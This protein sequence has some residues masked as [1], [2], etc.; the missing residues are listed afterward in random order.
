MSVT[1]AL[2]CPVPPVPV[3]LS[4]KVVALVRAAVL[5]LPAVAFDPDQPPE[6]VHAVAFVEVQVSVLLPPLATEVGD[7]DSETV[8]AGVAAVTVTDAVRCVV[9]PAPLQLS[10]YE[11]L[12]L[13]A[14]VLC[15][16]EVDFVP[17]QLPDAV[18]DVAFDVDHDKVLL[19]PLVTD[20]GDAEN[21]TVGAGVAAVTVTDALRWVVPPAPLQL[22]VYEA[23]EVSAPVPCEPDVAFDPLQLPD[24]VHD[25]AFEVD[26]DKVLL[27]PLVTEVG[28]AEKETVGAG[29]AA[30]TVTDAVRCVVPPEPEQ[31]SVYEA[32]AVSAPVLC[33][34]DVD[35]DPLQ[36]PEAEHDDAF[37][38]DHVNV[39]LP[40]LDTDVGDA[41]NETVGGVPLDDETATVTFAWRD[42]PA[43]EQVRT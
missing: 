19:P 24:A 26:H 12:A 17:L 40:P 7:A 41:E 42:P 6:A 37:V 29:V 21:E 8:G 23:S 31:V 32:L 13:N 33:E 36:L 34:P 43:P 1:V 28:D 20:V 38:A 27:P 22:S 5:S 10:V 15:E 9:P 16:P 3:Q 14:P 30:V 18:Q 39:L 11:A 2:A 35:F 25:V 4:V